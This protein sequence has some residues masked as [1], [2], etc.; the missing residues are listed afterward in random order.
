M[1]FG[2]FCC[3][4]GVCRRN[5][6]ATCLRRMLSMRE[7]V[8][9]ACGECFFAPSALPEG[10]R[11]RRFRTQNDRF[12]Q[13]FGASR[14]EFSCIAG[15]KRQPLSSGRVVDAERRVFVSQASVSYKNSGWQAEFPTIAGVK[16][17]RLFSDRVAASG[18]QAHT[19]KSVTP[20]GSH[21]ASCYEASQAPSGVCL[22]F[23]C[24]YS[25]RQIAP[26]QFFEI[27]SS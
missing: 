25:R 1:R 23:V 26:C 3:V 21:V 17:R 7:A 16:R 13:I 18:E 12:L 20:M 14:A 9:A 15:V 11:G 10:R 22:P 27:S 19:A 24:A 2:S 8:R 5:R 6:L 4:C